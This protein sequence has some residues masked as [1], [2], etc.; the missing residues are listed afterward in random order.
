MKRYKL[1][2]VE[3]WLGAEEKKLLSKVIDAGWVT[4]AVLTKEF[5]ARL[6]RYTKARYALVIN[7][8]T[9]ALFT[10]LKAL[11][12]GSGDEVLVPDLTFIATANAVILSGA[13][14]V[15]V[16]V[17]S[18]TFGMDV[19]KAEDKITSRTKA[20]LPVHLY[21]FPADVEGI[22]KIA[23]RH[24][25]FVIEDAAQGMGVY[26]KKRHVG[27]FGDAGV[28]SFYGN[29]TITC[30]EGAVLLTNNRNLYK[31]FYRLKNH[32][33]DVKGTFVHKTI[34]YNFCFTEM[35]AAVGIAQLGKLGEI[36]NRKKRIR[37]LYRSLLFGI[38]HCQFPEASSCVRP[39]FWFTNI[40]VPSAAG[41]ARFLAS[42]GVPS[43]RFFY[44]LH[45]QP[46]YRTFRFGRR[47]PQ[48]ADLYMQG[49]SLPSSVTT[50]LRDIRYAAECV[51]DY[52]EK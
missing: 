35:Q 36:I 40:L 52:F 13:K 47:F 12:I 2:V 8:G 18:K 32:G 23:R 43:R 34:G 30:G 49:L 48:S 19:K 28:I 11:G 20:I 3:P 46:C 21:G 10:A 1:P 25:L 24:R 14:P 39:V 7:N 26:Y 41:L 4:E 6:K 9:L 37:E 44:P 51:R 42:R 27:T 33:R 50:T 45:L 38:N 31:K 29:K 16:D 22:L 15:L 17:E 5:E